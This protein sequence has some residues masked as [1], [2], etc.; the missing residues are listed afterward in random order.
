MSLI[1]HIAAVGGHRIQEMGL[2][3]SVQEI[4]ISELFD[5]LIVDVKI[6]FQPHHAIT[7]EI[8]LEGIVMS[9]LR[10]MNHLKKTQLA[11]SQCCGGTFLGR[12]FEI[13]LT[14]RHVIAIDRVEVVTAVD[15]TLHAINIWI[16]TAL[17]ALTF[18]RM[19]LFIV[20][21]TVG[22]PFRE[23]QR[24]VDALEFFAVLD[25]PLGRIWVV[26][27][28]SNHIEHIIEHLVRYGF[29]RSLFVVGHW[30]IS[31][32]MARWE[33]ER[34]AEKRSWLGLAMWSGQV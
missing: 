21:N 15:C 13:D 8:E 4:T 32:W 5:R 16:V 11:V 25:A 2:D 6:F 1:D 33:R 29:D 9:L 7:N 31:V 34:P 28:H 30:S 22:Q 23:P 18:N 27:I 10:I 14:D 17:T 24:T 19:P 20:F 26:E 12:E 3:V